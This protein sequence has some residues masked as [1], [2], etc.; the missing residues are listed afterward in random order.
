MV[1]ADWYKQFT[2]SSTDPYPV[3]HQ[4][5]AFLRSWLHCPAIKQWWCTAPDNHQLSDHAF[6]KHFFVQEADIAVAPLAV[7]PEREQLVDFTDPFI[8]MVS[9]IKQPKNVKKYTDTFGF[10]K[11]L[12]KEIWVSFVTLKKYTWLIVHVLTVW[13]AIYVFKLNINYY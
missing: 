2:S 8:A 13:M 6:Q 1:T 7:T 5:E 10:L 12:S 11:P 9:P 4:L 3:L